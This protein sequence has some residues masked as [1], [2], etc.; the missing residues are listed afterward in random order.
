MKNPGDQ[1]IV[2]QF[3]VL[4]APLLFSSFVTACASLGAEGD[5]RGVEGGKM[6]GKKEEKK[7]LLHGAASP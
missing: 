2:T 7:T 6:D 4:R 1:V 3:N 5:E